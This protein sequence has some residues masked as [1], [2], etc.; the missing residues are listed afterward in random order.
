MPSL[1]PRKV[2]SPPSLATA[3]RTR[4]SIRS[5]MVVTISS[6][7]L[8]KNSFSSSLW[9]A[10]PA[11]S[12]GAPDMKCSMMAPRMAGLSCGHSPSALVTVMKSE[13]KN[14]PLMP[15]I[16]NSR[17][18]SGDFAASAGS[19]RSSVPVSS[20]VWPGRNFRVAGL[21]VASVW[22][23]IG[24]LLRRR[25]VQGPCGS[26]T[27]ADKWRLWRVWSTAAAFR[28]G[29]RATLRHRIELFVAQVP[30]HD[31]D[32]DRVVAGGGADAGHQ[33]PRPVL[34]GRGAENQ[35]GN[36]LVLLDQAEDLVGG[37]ALAHHPFRRDAGD[38]VGPGR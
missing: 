19:R 24:R 29:L 25:R 11:R 23:N 9:P 28:K 34:A 32:R 17:S 8:S 10:S 27:I 16:A 7:A 26:I 13:P 33:R 3:G 6:S 2:M 21:G 35:D 31:G 20:T 22:M 18:A 1:K 38:A 4:V 30:R 36:V 12:S 37:R 15:L 5:L 14:T